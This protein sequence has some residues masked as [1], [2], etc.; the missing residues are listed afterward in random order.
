MAGFTEV[1][2]RFHRPPLPNQVR[3]RTKY[4]FLLG[5]FKFWIR[6]QHS[7]EI[8]VV[9]LFLI[10][11]HE[12]PPSFFAFF[13]LHLVLIYG[14]LRIELWEALMKVFVNLIVHLGKTKLRTR[15]SFKD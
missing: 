3:Q 6:S 5:I 2:P 13:T 7:P 11:H 8:V 9:D 14:L 12:L 1:S 4:C 15:R 10:L